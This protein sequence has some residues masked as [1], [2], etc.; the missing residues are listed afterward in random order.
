MRYHKI[1]DETVRRL[2]I[3]LR[4][5]MLSATQ[6]REHI[7]SK[8]L[9]DFVGVNSWQIRKDFSYFGDFGT[10]GVGYNI[11]SLAKQIKKILRLDVIRKAA[12]VGV[13][14]LGSALLAYPGFRTYGLDIV[15]AF[16]VDPK[17]IGQTVNGVKIENITR[18]ATLQ[19]RGISLGIVAV[20]HTAGQFTVDKLAEAGVRG[21]LN[22][23]PCKIEAP[24]RVKVITLDIAMELARLPYYMPA[25]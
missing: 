12:L 19:E 11:E 2:P 9:A 10:P 14:D 15:A 23:A 4:G 24:R 6:G 17:K 7:S 3:Y 8:S 21:I 5:L 13:G 20:P 18:I 1:P 22:F 16:D 25:G